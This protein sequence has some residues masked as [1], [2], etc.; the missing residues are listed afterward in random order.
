MRK[1]RKHPK[2]EE[3]R[4]RWGRA[5]VLKGNPTPNPQPKEPPTAPAVA[6]AA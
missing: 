1:E 5:R 6:L 4:R 2:L 3:A